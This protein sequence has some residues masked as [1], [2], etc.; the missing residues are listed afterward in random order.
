MHAPPIRIITLELL[1]T[2]CR[3]GTTVVAEHASVRKVARCVSG[4]LFLG[5]KTEPVCQG[6]Q[7]R[8]CCSQ[9][10]PTRGFDERGAAAAQALADTPPERAAWLLLVDQDAVVDDV[11]FN[12]PLRRYGDADLVLPGDQALVAGDQYRSRA[13]LKLGE[14]LQGAL[15]R[16]AGAVT[17]AEPTSGGP[18]ALCW[19]RETHR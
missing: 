16:R 15:W 6:H 1:A 10:Y 9:G 4:R 11:S 12:L 8:T 7:T 5:C 19:G 3:R 13:S 18:H 2:P 17:T 14:P